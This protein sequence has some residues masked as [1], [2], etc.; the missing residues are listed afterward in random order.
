M[1]RRGPLKCRGEGG[2]YFKGGRRQQNTCN[3]KVEEGT[4]CERVQQ[5]KGETLEESSK[6]M[7]VIV[8]GKPV[9]LQ[10]NLFF[11]SEV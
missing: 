4:G 11:I 1:N 2:G 3:V 7:Y 8:T 5:E 6:S 9:I 10:S